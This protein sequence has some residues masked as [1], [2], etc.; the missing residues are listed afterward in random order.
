MHSVA[1]QLI[2]DTI[3]GRR[4]P[5]A[6]LV[7]NEECRG[8]V[9]AYET[10][11]TD[12]LGV[13]IEHA[14]D[15]IE[16][17]YASRNPSMSFQYIMDHPQYPWDWEVNVFR[18][19]NIK[20]RDVFAHPEIAWDWDWLSSNPDLKLQTVLDNLDKDWNW[21]EVCANIAMTKE[22]IQELNGE[23]DGFELNWVGLSRNKYITYDIVESL[24]DEIDWDWEMLSHEAT[25]ISI[26]DIM[27]NTDQ[28]WEWEGI[29]YRNT[30]NMHHILAHPNLDWDWVGISQEANITM[31]D[32]LEYPGFNW[33]YDALILNKAITVR[34]IVTH[35]DLFA[36]RMH[37]L[38]M[39][40][41]ITAEQASRIDGFTNWQY[42]GRH[43]NVDF[44]DII[45]YFPDTPRYWNIWSLNP[46]LTSANVLSNP[47]LNWDWDNLS[48]NPF[49]F[50]KLRKTFN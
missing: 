1:Q 19:P 29:S 2:R 14:P 13:L 25:G 21:E 48:N 40:P 31:D 10:L 47:Q 9:N 12:H 44:D 20:M 4:P 37:L 43:N 42:F 39:N 6:S 7:L 17:S 30:L 38:N 3:A 11:M 5:T 32:V 16:W 41:N 49:S 33:D 45:T 23:P 15:R 34:D 18:N 8:V 35:P 22:Q 28:P 36:G 46:N 24:E 50:P 27:A 26:D